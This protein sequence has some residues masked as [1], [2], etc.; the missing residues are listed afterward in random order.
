MLQ[1]GVALHGAATPKTKEA[2]TTF[3]EMMHLDE[4]DHLVSEVMLWCMADARK[5]VIIRC[6]YARTC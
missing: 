6:M 4:E 3:Q 5:G 2:V 1:L